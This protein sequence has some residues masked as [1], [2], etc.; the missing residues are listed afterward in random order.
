MRLTG[1]TLRL[2]Q[3][4]GSFPDLTVDWP[5]AIALAKGSTTLSLKIRNVDGRLLRSWKVDASALQRAEKEIATANCGAVTMAQ[6]PVEKRQSFD[7]TEE[8]SIIVTQAR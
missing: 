5:D 1:W 7:P 2:S 4:R 6:K 3:S 8:Q